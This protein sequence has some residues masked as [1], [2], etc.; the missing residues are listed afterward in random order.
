MQRER[1]SSL[2]VEEAPTDTC[3][4][5]EGTHGIGITMM[6]MIME[7]KQDYDHNDDVEEVELFG[8]YVGG[9]RLAG[10]WDGKEL[11]SLR[12]G[13]WLTP[14]LASCSFLNG[15][16]FFIA[17]IHWARFKLLHWCNISVMQCTADM[18]SI[19]KLEFFNSSICIIR[20]FDLPRHAQAFR[21]CL[22]R[23][24][25]FLLSKLCI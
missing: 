6:I 3:Q 13:H 18:C 5:A 21:A 15:I 10:I 24:C 25:C 7:V 20:V 11:D 16:L 19:S 9:Y 14:G 17:I 4:L 8:L 2:P 1:P 23:C 22:G 12:C